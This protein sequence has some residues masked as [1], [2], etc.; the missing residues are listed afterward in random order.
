[1]AAAM[2]LATRIGG[3]AVT[4]NVPRIF[5]RE[6]NTPAMGALNAAEMPAAA[7]QATSTF[8]RPGPERKN[9]PMREPKA[10]PVTATGPSAPTD[11][12]VP[13]RIAVASVFTAAGTARIMPPRFATARMTSGMFSPSESRAP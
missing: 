12:P 4:P 6:K 7:P 3:K 8:R 13:M 10:A 9:R 11:P 1:M 5:S 2:T